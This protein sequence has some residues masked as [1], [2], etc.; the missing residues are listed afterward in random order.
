[1]R[2]KRRRL[3]DKLVNGNN[4]RFQR[5]RRQRVEREDVETGRYS[6]ET[7]CVPDV[8]EKRND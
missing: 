6:L 5:K 2:K 3:G 4:P 8:I 1:M 7:C